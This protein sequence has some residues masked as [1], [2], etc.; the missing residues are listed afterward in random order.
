MNQNSTTDSD[1]EAKTVGASF[2]KG[3]SAF[4]RSFLRHRLLYLARHGCNIPEE[5]SKEALE[6]IAAQG[7]DVAE[8][9]ETARSTP[10]A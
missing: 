2:N 4:R 3:G 5:F 6:Q 10:K 9:M 7:V 1:W 8:V